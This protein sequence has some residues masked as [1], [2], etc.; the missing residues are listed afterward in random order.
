[1]VVSSRGS[2]QRNDPDVVTDIFLYTYIVV[3]TM[4]K[5]DRI[6]QTKNLC[7][8]LVRKLSFQKNNDVIDIFLPI[9]WPFCPVEKQYTTVAATFE[10]NWKRGTRN[11]LYWLLCRGFQQLNWTL[12]NWKLV[13]SQNWKYVIAAHFWI[14]P[15][16]HFSPLLTGLN[17]LHIGIG[18]N[19]ALI[20]HFLDYEFWKSPNNK[21]L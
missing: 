6:T 18:Q 17:S 4:S 3:L 2:F 21:I 9:I 10:E 12:F 19:L 11:D 14:F 5:A 15:D 13:N 7:W 20:P 1:M 8:I 16:R